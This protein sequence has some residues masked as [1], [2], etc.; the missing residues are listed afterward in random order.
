MRVM[1][2]R[3]GRTARVSDNLADRIKRQISSG[4][5]TAG[6]KL[7]AEREM[8]RRYNT[9]R[10]SVREA[11]RSLEELGL[12]AIRRGAD[13]GAFINEMGHDAVQRS[14][15]LVLKLGRTSHQ[16]LTEARLLIEPPIARLAARRARPEDI[17]KLR[18]V[19]ERQEG[20]LARKGHFRPHSLLFHRA[21]A[22]CAGN[23]PLRTLMNSLSDLILEIVSVIDTARSVK[24]DICRFHRAIFEAIERH[25]EDAAH[26]L[27]LEHIG[28]VQ[29]GIGE[30][31]AQQLQDDKSTDGDIRPGKS[32]VRRRRVPASACL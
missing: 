11:Y 29:D 19:L 14:L 1:P 23:L 8:A 20:A 21:V 5:L 30:T 25:D 24:E 7:P 26:Q 28:H 22:E 10:V 4:K 16:E 15:S 6:E 9:S 13:G 31:L 18:L 27:M 3:P 32:A 2:Q 12:L 17:A